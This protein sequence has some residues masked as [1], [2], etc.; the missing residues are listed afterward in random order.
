MLPSIVTQDAFAKINVHLA[1]SARR[2]DGYHDLSSLFQLISL[3]DTVRVSASVGSGFSCSVKGLENICTTGEDTMGKAARLW[4]ER[5]G[6]AGDISIECIKRIPVQAGLGGGSSDAAAVLRAL[7]SLFPSDALGPAG[8]M[9][10]GLDIGSDVPF[11]L[12]GGTSAWG[13]GRGELLE[14]L[15]TPVG[16]QVLVVMPRTFSVSTGKAFS[17]LD[18][19]REGSR[20]EVAAQFSFAEVRRLYGGDCMDWPFYNDFSP[21]VGHEK[22]YS[23]LDSA[24]KAVGNTF[25]SLTGSGA[26]WYA[27]SLDDHALDAVGRAVATEFGDDVCTFRAK[28]LCNQLCDGTL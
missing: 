5:S 21:V 17:R 22:F 16:Y 15:D 12:C 20:K 27:V 6:V 10:I 14:V 28:M 7:D 26:A 9:E 24:C 1:V 25:G 18:A 23:V 4:C 2:E 13:R 19:L 8:L 3:H 11:F